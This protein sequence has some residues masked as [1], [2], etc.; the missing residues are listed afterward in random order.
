LSADI[1]Q[2]RNNK[3]IKN[4]SILTSK[5]VTRTT[6]ERGCSGKTIKLRETRKPL[7][8]VDSSVPIMSR[9]Q[10]DR[11]PTFSKAKKDKPAPI[12]FDAQQII[13]Y[14]TAKDLP[15][16]EIGSGAFNQAVI[17]I[18]KALNATLLE[19]F[20]DPELHN[21]RSF[22]FTVD[23]IKKS[24]DNFYIAAYNDNY[25]PL[26][27]KDKQFLRGLR[28]KDFLYN[29]LAA[30]ENKSHLFKYL[31]KRKLASES[32][33]LA[34]KDTHPFCTNEVKKWYHQEFGGLGKE[35]TRDEMNTM[36]Q[37]GRK[38]EEFLVTHKGKLQI[39]DKMSMYGNY[40]PLN[41]LVGQLL[42]CASKGLRENDGSRVGYKLYYLISENMLGVRFI[43]FLR[44]E[45]MI[46]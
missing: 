20:V 11:R 18:T 22:R 39:E 23:S 3:N 16:H 41:F 8:I 9:L 27:I 17:Y 30:D 31:S 1:L 28:L 10:G 6:A 33:F 15:G 32:K 26:K 24:I 46:K 25:E 37:V 36:I 4:K 2:Q 13:D 35:V 12:T 43:D 29:R 42:R 45:R 44:S 40:N 38:L 19:G 14:W 7:N 5:E 21:F 34:L